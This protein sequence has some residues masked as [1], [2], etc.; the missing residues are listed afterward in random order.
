MDD[1]LSKPV[2]AHE[3]E[4]MPTSWFGGGQAVLHQQRNELGGEGV[5]DVAQLD[6]LRE[7]A[8]A[9]LRAEVGMGPS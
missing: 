1:Y 3:L 5:L 4:A 6:G 7:L 8:A 9:A 2:K